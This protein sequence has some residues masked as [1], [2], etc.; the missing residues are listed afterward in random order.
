MQSTKARITKVIK[1]YIKTFPV[2]YEQFLMS[3]RKKQDNKTNKWGEFKQSDQMVRHLFDIPES[4][5]MALKMKLTDD[6]FNW[7]YGFGDYEGKR[8]GVTWFIRNFPQFKITD[9]F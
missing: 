6:Q 3:H 5:F 7:F 2:E 1:E 4:L 9:D 8:D